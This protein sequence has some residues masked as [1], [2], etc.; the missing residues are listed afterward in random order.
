MPVDLESKKLFVIGQLDVTDHAWNI[1]PQQYGICNASRLSGNVHVFNLSVCMIH[2]VLNGRSVVNRVITNH[3]GFLNRIRGCIG[4]TGTVAGITVD[5]RQFVVA[6]VV[7]HITIGCFTSAAQ[8]ERITGSSLAGLCYLGAEFVTQFFKNRLG[9][10]Q[11]FF[12]VFV[13]SHRLESS[14]IADLVGNVTQRLLHHGFFLVCLH[15]F[16]IRFKLHIG[17]ES[18]KGECVRLLR[19]LLAFMLHVKH[20]SKNHACGRQ[21]IGI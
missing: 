13:I 18:G 8:V 3:T 1:L 17:Q 21:R 5:K 15:H 19:K 2:K 4:S 11:K 9:G 20:R 6:M 10:Q 7:Y 14:L 12:G 16:Y